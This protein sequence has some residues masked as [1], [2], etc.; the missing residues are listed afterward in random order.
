[1]QSSFT[2]TS[3]TVCEGWLRKE[4]HDVV[5]KKWQDRYFVLESGYNPKLTYYTDGTKATKKGEWVFHDKTT[6]KHEKLLMKTLSE[7]LFVVVGKSEHSRL[8][9]NLDELFLCADNGLVMNQWISALEK[10]S[11]KAEKLIS[12]RETEDC[13]WVYDCIVN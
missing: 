5:M 7:F 6:V 12:L 4:S 10:A 13:M 1:M 9:N 11:T 2:V 8:S 3:K